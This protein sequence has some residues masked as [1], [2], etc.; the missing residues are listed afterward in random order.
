MAELDGRHG[1]QLIASAHERGGARIN[2]RHTRRPDWVDFCILARDAWWCHDEIGRVSSC[3]SV[4]VAAPGFRRLD[5][6][7]VISSFAEK[8][9]LSPNNR[10]SSSKSKTATFR[11]DEPVCW[12]AAMAKGGSGVDD[13][14][15]DARRRL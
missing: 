1:E 3:G 15:V 13:A 2:R 5:G 4:V 14:L 8:S 10:N 11:S 12:L 9:H 7:K 6:I